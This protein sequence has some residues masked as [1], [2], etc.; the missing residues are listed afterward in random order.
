MLDDDA[1]E[2]EISSGE[3]IDYVSI[4]F[5]FFQSNRF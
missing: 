4:Q 2:G 1:E 5:I 3:E